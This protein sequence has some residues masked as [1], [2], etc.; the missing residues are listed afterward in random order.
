MKGHHMTESQKR[1]L[2]IALWTLIPASSAFAFDPTSPYGVTAFIPS[3]NRWQ[4]M[5]D[6]MIVWN[7]C[8][9][10]WRDVET[11]QNVFNW[12]QT[13]QMVAEANARGL[14]IYAGLGYTPAWASSSSYPQHRSQ[15]PPANPA[16]WA[17][18]VTQ[19]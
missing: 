19:A 18:Y 17:D 11:S 10:S 3:P 9:F 15:D 2:G 7:R 12:A 16:D 14:Q 8:Q 4:A 1:A 5:Q 13:D 6:A